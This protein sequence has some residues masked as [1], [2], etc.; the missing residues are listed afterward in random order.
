MPLKRMK[1]FWSAAVLSGLVF[2]FLFSKQFGYL[3]MPVSDQTALSLSSTGYIAD[4]STWR[5]VYQNRQKIGVSHSTFKRVESGY[6][7][8][9]TLYLRINTMGMVQD[10]SLNTR[11]KLH[12]DFSLAAFDFEITSGR[13]RFTA[14]GS[15]SGETLSVMSYAAGSA[16]EFTL[17]LN[18]KIYLTAGIIDAVLA[19]D[20]TPKKPLA[21]E[22]FDPA[23]LSQ[24]P[25]LIELVG[26]E[27]I[28]VMGK[29]Q[30]AKKISLNFKG[31]TQYAWISA[32]GE[33]LKEQG[34]LGISLEKT[35]R[36]QALS[37]LPVQASQD[38]TQI[39]S[40]PVDTTIE[41]AQALERLRLKVGGISF[42]NLALDGGRQTFQR[43]V[44]TIVRESLP[45][46]SLGPLG[47][48]D[49]KGLADFLEPSALI[50]SDHPDI[51]SLV[52]KITSA[53]DTP[54]LKARK[55]MD[56]IHENIEKRPVLSLPDALSTLTNR[57]G[58]CNE[59]AMLF[60]ALTRAV[61]IP[62]KIET[63]LVYLNGRFYYHA[64]NALFLGRWIT[65][66]S[67]FGQLPA[68]VTHIRFSSGARN[69]GLDMMTIIGK[70]NLQVIH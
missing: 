68:D 53:A 38:L 19:G 23:T 26:I 28:S 45:D 1:F 52:R 42:E 43:P 3:D 22:V 41:N 46:S 37:G 34:L 13:F 25:V 6:Q 69:L 70:V 10:I 56:W 17:K 63:G 7:L 35:T 33:I 59:H 31:I 32:D 11:G 27:D 20:L 15:V 60:A 64:W 54:L 5:N 47:A 21:L 12:P 8:Q 55:L 62:S 39:A 9:E 18:Q 65:A 36:E 57:V 44:L 40:V 67:L 30:R 66:D 51:Q 2:T 24:V 4:R 50:Q 58:D 61:G 14:T 48:Q 16:R 29:D 49:L